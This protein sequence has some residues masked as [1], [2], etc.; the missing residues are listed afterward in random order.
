MSEPLLRAY[1]AA[2]MDRETGPP[3][4]PGQFGLVGSCVGAA[5]FSASSLA[6]ARSSV[7]SSSSTAQP[8]AAASTM[9]RM[10]ACLMAGACCRRTEPANA[11]R[12]YRSCG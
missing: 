5:V 8:T 2:L 11:R 12:C 10:V 1:M 9:I 4:P 7:L 3:L 6:A